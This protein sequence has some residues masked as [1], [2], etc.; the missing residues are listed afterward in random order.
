[1]PFFVSSENAKLFEEKTTLVQSLTTQSSGNWIIPGRENKVDT[2]TTVEHKDEYGVWI[3]TKYD[4]ISDSTKLDINL[5]QFSLMLKGGGWVPYTLSMENPGDTVVNLRFVRTKIYLDDG[6]DVDVIQT[7]FNIETKCDTR[8]DYEATLEVRF[9]FFI[10]KQKSM[11]VNHFLDSYNDDRTF[12]D[13]VG[14]ITRLFHFRFL[15]DFFRRIL[16]FSKIRDNNINPLLTASE[17]YF[18]VKIGFS[19]PEGNEGPARVDTRFF[20]GR[21][22][23]RDPMVLRMKITPYD[24]GRGFKISYFNSYRTVDEYGNEAFYRH[25]NIDFDPAA[26]LQITSIPREARISYN[27]GSSAGTATKISFRAVGGRFSDIVQ[28]FIIDP[29]PEYMSFDLTVIGERSFRYESD[30]SYSVT[31][32]VDS[33]QNGNLVKLELFDLPKKMDV[34]WGLSI[35]LD[36]KT[37]LG[38]IDLNM[39]NDIGKAS[40]YLKGS[41]KPFIE[42][43]N[44]P[45]RLHLKSYIDV[46]NLKGY[47]S[48]SKYTGVTT[49]LYVPI[50]FDKWEITSTLKIE[51]GH[52]K[53]SFDL[54]SEDSRHI[55]VGLDTNNN[56]M[57]G[58]ELSIVNTE[59]NV[60]VLYVSVDGIAT[61]DLM[62]SW[63]DDGSGGVTNFKWSG[64]ITKLINLVISINFR[65]LYF[66]ISTSWTLGESGFFELRLKKDLEVTFVDI[67]TSEFKMYGHISLYA[68]RFLKIDWEWGETGHFTIYT[69]EPIGESLYLEFGYGAQQEGVY[70]YGFKITATDYLWLTRTIM[71]DTEN[72]VVP[73]IWIL[74]DEPLPGNWDVWLLWKYKWYE[75]K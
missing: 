57:F 32:L 10:L 50:I 4:G 75:V 1:M 41:E 46:P 39:S 11:S 49:T 68:D 21:E 48:A 38:F 47:V 55:E 43:L 59:T 35:N 71:W 29:L 56:V 51:D 25:F 31:Y 19:S 34:S 5:E 22:S 9:P 33:L 6:T 45:R 40:L 42:V 30:R 64:R 61:D 73:R 7:Q 60:E 23:L 18:S 66:D 8:E 58:I 65:G 20:F 24:L 16:V 69:P 62:I 37:A 13:F 36:A 67:E 27:F 74:G 3:H 17:S 2:N 15:E 72:G 28:S 26:E 12:F 54:P 14:K 44:F 52:G 70:Q 63:D 53:V